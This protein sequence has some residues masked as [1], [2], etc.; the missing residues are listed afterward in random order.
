MHLQN[1]QR[2]LIPVDFSESA[3]NCCIYICEYAL[4]M[5]WEVL[6]AHV[7][8][9]VV[10]PTLTPSE[11]RAGA[12]E[13]HL[14]EARVEMLQM[15]NKLRGIFPRIPLRAEILERPD[16]AGAIIEYAKKE[17]VHLI[18]MAT[19]GSKGLGSF[20]MPS[21]TASVIDHSQNR[22]PVFV[23]PNYFHFRPLKQVLLS[24]DLSVD[25]DISRLESLNKIFPL[26]D[27]ELS[28]LHIGDTD[29]ID[30]GLEILANKIGD[31][32]PIQQI[33]LIKHPRGGKGVI[34][35]LIDVGA[36]FDTLIL[37]PALRSFWQQL[38]KTS[39]TKSMTQLAQTPLIVLP[40][41]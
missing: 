23:V 30:T 31:T 8:H 13:E 11:V 6:L 25:V 15:E 9:G 10:L 12:R 4:R 7:V 3:L 22:F 28:I 36:N 1:Q 38:F 5:G 33:Q 27:L 21:N 16:F 32:Y 2:V 26:S 29:T 35:S 18:A 37:M 24:V 41:T 17:Q 19:K 20:F 14:E 40:R 39:I 34:N